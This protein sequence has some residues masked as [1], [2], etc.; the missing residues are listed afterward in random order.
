MQ[1]MKSKKGFTL[2]EMLIVVAIIGILI[3]VSI[4]LVSSSLEKARI[5]TDTAN[6]RAAKAAALVIYLG[7]DLKDDDDTAPI[8]LGD[9]EAGVYYDAA[10]GKIEKDGTAAKAAPYGKCKDHQDGILKVYVSKELGDVTAEWVDK[11]GDKL[12]KSTP[13]IANMEHKT[14]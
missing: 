3:A 1:K 10:G 8:T 12:D 13:H 5:A 14:T 2:I 11:T 6:E 7:S 9:L 4:P